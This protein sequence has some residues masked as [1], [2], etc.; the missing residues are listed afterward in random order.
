MAA[1]TLED[2]AAGQDGSFPAFWLPFQDFTAHNHIAQW[3]DTVVTPP[4]GCSDVGSD[5][6]TQACCNG[7]TCDPTTHLCDGIIF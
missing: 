1:V 6:S 3:V 7:E 4:A 5:C 2:I